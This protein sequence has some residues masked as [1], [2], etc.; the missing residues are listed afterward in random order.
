MFLG[1]RVCRFH[2]RTDAATRGVQRESLLPEGRKGAFGL[3]KVLLRYFRESNK[4]KAT[5]IYKEDYEKNN[6]R[7]GRQGLGQSQQPQV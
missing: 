1:A 5:F 3:P 2:R 6:K 4:G 7:D